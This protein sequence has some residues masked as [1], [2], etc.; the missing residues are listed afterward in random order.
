MV[1][2]RLQRSPKKPKEL[3][4]K[5]RLKKQQGKKKTERWFHDLFFIGKN[6][7]LY[8]STMFRG[9]ELPPGRLVA[10]FDMQGVPDELVYV[11][12][13]Q[14]KFVLRLGTHLFF[15]MA[16]LPLRRMTNP[17]SRTSRV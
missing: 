3:P 8:S 6:L 4:K 11:I 15:Q 7:R 16:S 2:H 17:S 1:L 10:A 12:A 14:D 13:F 9:E 5:G